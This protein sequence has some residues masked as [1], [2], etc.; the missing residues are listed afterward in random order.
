MHVEPPLSH[1]R[2]ASRTRRSLLAALSGLA[3]V[4]VIPSAA[5]GGPSVPRVWVSTW[6]S[7]PTSVPA[8]GVTTVD[9]ATIRQVVH[10]SAPGDQ[11]Q[12]R[13][14]NE[15]GDQP[16]VI[17]EA[18]LA[19]RATGAATTDIDPATDTP[20]AF[21]GQ[22]TVII[23]AGAAMISD[24]VALPLPAS[25]DLVVSVH[26][27]SSTPITTVHAFALQDNVLAAG[28]VTAAPSVT[29]TATIGQWSLLSGVSV[30]TRAAGAASIIAFGDSITDGY[31]TTVNANHRWSD[32]LAQRLSGCGKLRSR[33]VAN[34]GITGN[35]LLHDEP[36]APAGHP[37]EAI[38]GYFGQSA[39]GRFDR[40]VLSQPA[41]R[42]V[43]VLLGI[44]D[45]GQPGSLAPQSE[46]VSV[47]D[48]IGA[49]RQIITRAHAAGLTVYGGTLLPFKGNLLGYDSEA[50]EAARQAVNQ[51]IR[52]SGAYDAVIDFDAVMGEPGDPLTLRAAYNS[53]DGLHPN[54]AGMQAMADA[55]PL[56]LFR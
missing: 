2:P 4:A 6:A 55:I 13:L 56:R 30:R 25:A 29:P 11:V 48:I 36:T 41:A 39:L 9:D 33:G 47:Q 20:V 28:N 42:Y 14:T 3:L 18:R 38:A 5:A 22:P 10:T 32:L 21:N 31:A 46:A 43:I 24:A 16:L 53:G 44:N 8:A 7:A 50:N 51:W 49:H 15:F 35:R 27:P 45:L 54:D 26:L 52:T 34:L 37:A 17:G 40:D 23:P 12:I 1:H 19:V